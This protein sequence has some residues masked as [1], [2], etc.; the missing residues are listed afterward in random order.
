MKKKIITL[1]LL[2]LIIFAL[3]AC[4]QTDVVANKAVTTFET[5]LNTDTSRVLIDE[6]EYALISPNNTERFSFN[7]NIAISFELAPFVDAGLDVTKLPSHIKVDGNN[8]VISME[9]KDYS[10][11]TTVNTVFDELVKNNRDAIGYHAELDHFGV[12]LGNGNMFEWAK[13][14]TTNDKDIVFVLDPQAFIDI[15]VDVENVDG[16]LFA[17][18]K[19]MDNGK[20]VEVNK[21]LK[22][23]NIN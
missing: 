23:Y 21:L 12:A 15:G 6:D 3:T 4:S 17:K 11:K 18:V 22:P 9:N 8:L 2:T 14:I 10:N 20:K 19:T 7:K 13:D 1:S 5:V 16:W